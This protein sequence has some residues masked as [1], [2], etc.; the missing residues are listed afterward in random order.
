M[1]KLRRPFDVTTPAQ[2]AALASIDEQDE[3]ANR[4]RLNTDGLE[5]LEAILRDADLSPV[6][7]LGNF[8]YVDS[9]TDANVLFD[10]LLHE[11][12][13]VRPCGGFGAPTAV[14]ITVGSPDELDYFAAALSRVLQPA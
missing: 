9:G 13:I 4:R 5:R 7:S 10:R 1:A 3:I 11:G 12:V 8:V 14:R 6:P 2:V